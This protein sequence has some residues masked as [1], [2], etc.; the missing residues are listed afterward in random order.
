MAFDVYVGTMTRYYRREWENV[1]Q[2]MA[3][4]QGFN[5]NMIYAGGAP[6]PPQPAEEIQS[7]VADWSQM[8]SAGLQS[9]V[10]G[11][12]SWDEGEEQPYFTDRPGWPGYRGLLLWAA[13]AEHADLRPP[14]ALPD[15]WEDDLAFQKSNGEG[16]KSR[17]LQILR[18]Q[19]WIPADFNAVADGP[20]LCQN[21]TCI[22]STF[23]LKRQ[24]NELR[25]ETIERL[26]MAK[27]EPVASPQPKT[28][29][30]GLI[31]RLFSKMP[32]QMPVADNQDR[33]VDAAEFGLTIFQDLASK[34]CEHRL[35]ILLNF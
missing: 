19:L 20:D 7:I 24:L 16:F 23:E 13:Y 21:P 11:K 2:R 30:G 4:E 5:Y 8:L 22:G 26:K 3:R 17:F 18:A 27:L 6:S 14:T 28:K 33:L 31:R 32:S 15:S 10:V 9:L 34:A 29:S 25:D 12:I 1:A 35:P